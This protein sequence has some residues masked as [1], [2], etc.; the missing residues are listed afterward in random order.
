[1]KAAG[2][3]L[4][5][6]ACGSAA[7]AHDEKFSVSRIEIK[8][9]G[10]TWSVDVSLQGLEKLLKLPADPVDLS[11]SQF[12]GMKADIVAYLR[13]CMK[14]EING[15]LVDPEAGTLAP[16][17]ERYVASGEMVIAHA[18]Q[19]FRF[20]SAKPVKNVALHGAFFATKTDQH[21]AVLNIAWNGAK[22][23]YSRYGPFELDLTPSRIQPTFWSTAGEFLIWGAHHIFIGYDHIAFLLALLLA[24]TKLGDMV[25]VATSFTLAH[26]LTLLL[27]ALDKI[28]MPSAVTESLIAA[29]IVYVAAENYFVKE[30][31]Y[32]WVLTFVF[33]LVH[34]L[35][36]SS[37]L[38]DRLQDLD[39][40]VLPVLS[41]N[42]GVELGQVAILLVAFPILAWLRKGATEEA[43]AKRQLRLV[44]IGSAPILLLGCFWLV[45]RIF[46][47]N[48]MPF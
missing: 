10:L 14:V 15:G 24:A 22:R 13:T 18:R 5:L 2:T 42:L 19:E 44:R 12:Q 28:R 1:M 7:W 32:R 17:Y 41:F 23:S 31:K 47:K 21:H 16:L 26:S 38:R 46:Q 48:W 6:F 8:E 3:A 30:A 25:R 45:D 43:S 40:I 11:E 34:G 36:F 35:G 27:A 4:L 9:D 29:S 20:P 33:G 37:V 39:T